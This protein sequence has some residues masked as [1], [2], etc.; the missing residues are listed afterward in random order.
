MRNLT[1]P[2]TARCGTCARQPNRQVFFI[3]VYVMKTQILCVEIA[4]LR[5][6][7]DFEVICNYF[8]FYK[9]ITFLRIFVTLS[10]TLLDRT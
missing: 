8:S 5:K 2:K 10:M 6:L 9:T 3:I 7:G 1:G 4:L